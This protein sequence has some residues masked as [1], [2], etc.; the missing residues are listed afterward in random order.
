MWIKTKAC[1]KTLVAS[2]VYL[3]KRDSESCVMTEAE[4]LM[5]TAST[6]VKYQMRI[7][8][9]RLTMCVAADLLN[10]ADSG[11]FAVEPSAKYHSVQRCRLSM[12]TVILI[13][14]TCVK[15]TV[16]IF[17][18]PGQLG[19]QIAESFVLVNRVLLYRF[20]QYYLL[21]ILSYVCSMLVSF[22]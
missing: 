16:L 12:T 1:H 19:M 22:T 2:Q 14:Y 4:S 10:N 20:S 21:P 7:F 6:A 15:Q 8:Y 17:A 11:S 9:I 13:A 3:H 18:Q 5:L